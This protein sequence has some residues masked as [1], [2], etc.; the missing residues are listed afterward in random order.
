[1]RT[2][3]AQNPASLHILEN[4]DGNE[5]PHVTVS[6]ANCEH[7]KMLRPEMW[8]LLGG[9]GLCCHSHQMCEGLGMVGLSDSRVE[10]RSL[11]PV[12]WQ[13]RGYME[14]P[15]YF[16][17]H[18]LSFFIGIFLFKPYRCWLP[19]VHYPLFHQSKEV[20]VLTKTKIRMHW[21]MSQ[22]RPFSRGLLLKFVPET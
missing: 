16:C 8:V 20:Q 4:D 2:T 19:V 6:E 12:H 10:R 18:R 5:R 22:T 3:E 17:C 13:Y 7:W 11:L 1:M 14:L 15:S 9:K 21:E